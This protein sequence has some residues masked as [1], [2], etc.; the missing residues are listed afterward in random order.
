VFQIVK[1]QLEWRLSG[2]GIK[3]QCIKTQQP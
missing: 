2:S 3:V 1:Q